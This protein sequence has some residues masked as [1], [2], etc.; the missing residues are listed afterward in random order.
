MPNAYHIIHVNIDL[1]SQNFPCVLS[2]Y[3]RPEGYILSG[4]WPQEE[5]KEAEDSYLSLSLIPPI[6]VV[7]YQDI[8]LHPVLEQEMVGKMESLSSGRPYLLQPGS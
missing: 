1:I 5:R 6:F 4:P 2:N 8:H 3:K 7:L